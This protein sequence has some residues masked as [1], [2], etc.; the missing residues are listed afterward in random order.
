VVAV[1]AVVA[2]AAVVFAN[3]V[4]CV[5]DCIACLTMFKLSNDCFCS[6]LNILYLARRPWVTFANCSSS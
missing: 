1:V 6:L 5:N 3:V 2:V 4:K